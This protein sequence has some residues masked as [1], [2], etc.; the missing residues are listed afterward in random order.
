[1]LGTEPWWRI[2]ARRLQRTGLPVRWVVSEA[3]SKS[4]EPHEATKV[5]GDDAAPMFAS[6]MAGI[7][8]I[9]SDSLHPSRAA[10]A[11]RGVF[12]LPVDVPAPQPATFL[13]LA[14]AMASAPPTKN[15][16]IPTHSGRHGHPIY[17]P[18]RFV[19]QRLLGRAHTP[20]DRLD[21]MIESSRIEVPVDDSCV[22]LNL[23]TAADFAGIAAREWGVR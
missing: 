7:E 14:E 16:A 5:P 22:V 23:N 1:M 15:A 2:Q 18:W 8:S 17:L 10:Q 12:I 19:R 9:D 4:M 13:R 6:I 11:V 21:R 3:V 20:D